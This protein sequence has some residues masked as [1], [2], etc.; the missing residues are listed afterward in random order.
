MLRRLAGSSVRGRLGLWLLVALGCIVTAFVLHRHSCDV[1]E[2]EKVWQPELVNHARTTPE[3]KR[4]TE[5]GTPIVWSDT[6]D[7]AQVDSQDA[8]GPPLRV[9]VTV[10]AIGRYLDKYLPRFLGTAERYFLLGYEVT[11]FVLTDFPSKVPVI[12][13]A[14]GRSLVSIKVKKQARWQDICMD[15]MKT[16]GDLV[17]STLTGLADYVFCFDVD[18][19]FTGPWGPEV[20]G[21]TVAVIHA[22][23]FSKGPLTFPYERRPKSAAYIAHGEGDFYYH[24]AVFGGCC[25]G[26]VNATRGIFRGIVRDREKGIEAIWH[27]ESHLNRYF[28]DNK[29]SKLLSPEYSWDPSMSWKDVPSVRMTYWP[30]EYQKVREHP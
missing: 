13:L 21:D 16:I 9:V 30:K 25:S 24:A 3:F 15:R 22:G 8:G 19:Y 1:G 27:D 29:P 18:Q 5:W 23:F 2:G 17:E 26:V 7:P 4:M 10:F 12:D 28:F 14:P 11:Y 20:L 6:L